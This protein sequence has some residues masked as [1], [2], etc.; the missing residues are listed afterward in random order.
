MFYETADYTN[1]NGGDI[2]IGEIQEPLFKKRLDEIRQDVRASTSTWADL[3]RQYPPGGSCFEPLNF[4]VSSWSSIANEDVRGLGDDLDADE[5]YSQAAAMSAYGVDI[6]SSALN[7]PTVDRELTQLANSL[8]ATL[9][10]T[11]MDTRDRHRDS[12]TK[13]VAEKVDSFRHILDGLNNSPQTE[14]TSSRME[15]IERDEQSIDTREVPRHVKV[16]QQYN[17][18]IL[19]NE[20]RVSGSTMSNR[21]HPY[22]QGR[23]H[24]PDSQR[25]QQLRDSGVARRN[26]PTSL[27][28]RPL[29]DIRLPTQYSAPLSAL[30]DHPPTG[31]DS[32]RIRSGGVD[33][34]SVASNP[35][36]V[37]YR[38]KGQKTGEKVNRRTIINTALLK[39][40]LPPSAVAK[41]INQVDLRTR[42]HYDNIWSH[43][44]D[45]CDER[46]VDPTKRSE[47]NLAKRLREVDSAER[48]NSRIKP[49]VC[50]VWRAI[51]G[52]IYS[53]DPDC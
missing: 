39:H 45:W 18:T 17:P 27:L 28:D 42:K 16:E 5:A 8:F 47:V 48:K 44:V 36:R 49:A 13:A 9:C 14:D 25:A 37:V 1:N 35:I 10:A 31:S 3:R 38:A 53:K 22:S 21:W 2:E 46:G 43:W 34:R 52:D 15:S 6:L 26:L 32:R 11:L 51:E 40:G 50:S 33:S 20:H 30:P 4:A 29:L 7:G 41:Y 24:S 23:S 19:Q 12:V